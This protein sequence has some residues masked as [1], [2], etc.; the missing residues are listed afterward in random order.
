MAAKK[1]G[2]SSAAADAQPEKDPDADFIQEAYGTALKN[3]VT[4]LI[5]NYIAG[6]PEPEKKFVAGLK[7]IRKARAQALKLVQG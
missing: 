4:V 3:Q 6:T 7:I 2:A 1:A 5:D